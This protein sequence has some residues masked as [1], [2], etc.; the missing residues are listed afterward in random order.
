MFKS[1]PKTSMDNS[2]QE[3][4]RFVVI[5][6]LDDVPEKKHDGHEL[7]VM[8][9][10]RCSKAS[11]VVLRIYLLAVVGLTLFRV[12]SLLGLVPRG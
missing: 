9:L 5:H 3:L 7:G 12:F 4:A 8:K 10:N 6:P 1:L 11:L 2:Q